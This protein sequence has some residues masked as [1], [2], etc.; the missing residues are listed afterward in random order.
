MLDRE[1]R[2]ILNNLTGNFQ[3]GEKFKE[4]IEDI[5]DYVNFCNKETE[6]AKQKLAEYNKDIELEKKDKRIKYLHEHSLLQLSDKELKDEKEF[7]Q[8]HYEKC[9]NKGT[10]IYEI[11]KYNQNHMS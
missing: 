2:K 10:Y 5:V 9:K 1:T 4:A 7:R 8:K 6:T 3:N 11:T